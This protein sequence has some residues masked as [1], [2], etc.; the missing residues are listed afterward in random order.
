MRLKSALLGGDCFGKNNALRQAAQAAGVNFDHIQKYGPCGGPN[1]TVRAIFGNLG[2]REIDECDGQP[3]GRVHLVNQNNH[4]V[5]FHLEGACSDA[6]YWD[7]KPNESITISGEGDNFY[8]ITVTS[9]G[10]TVSYGIDS[11]TTHAFQWRR[12]LL[13]VVNVTPRYGQ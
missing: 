13:D 6:Q 2:C 7:I 12:N 10:G 4:A 9:P 3:E 1:S 8:N 11:G 5:R